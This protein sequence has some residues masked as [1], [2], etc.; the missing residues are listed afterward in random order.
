MPILINLLAEQQAAVEARRRDPVKRAL[1]VSAGLVGLMV[2]WIALLQF[3]VTRARAEL[4][5]YESQL[6]KVEENSKE[7]RANWGTAGQLEN[8]LTN[9]QRYSTNRFF[10]ATVLDALQQ[11]MVEDVRVVHLQTLH[12]YSTNAE[13]T[14]KT[15]IVIPLASSHWWQFWKARVPQTNVAVLVANQIAAITNKVETLKGAVELITKTEVTTNAGM[16]TAKIDILKPTTAVEQI[17]LTLKARDYGN[18]PGRRIDDFSK[19]IATH[20]YF[21]HCLL[22]GEQGIRFKDRGINPE[23]DQGDPSAKPYVRLE[24]DCRYRETLRANE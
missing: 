19:A 1:W 16:A 23:F 4:N 8:R 3:R 11:L 24:V 5:R 22:Q 20:P 14:F 13:A 2:L 17:L 15:N 18:P 10:C 12:S 9:L 7:V 21:A 6:Q